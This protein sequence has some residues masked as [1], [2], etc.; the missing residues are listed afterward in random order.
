MDKSSSRSALPLCKRSNYT[1]GIF[2]GLGLV[3][4]TPDLQP[5]QLMEATLFR[6][7]DCG[8][9]QR[10]NPLIIPEIQSCFGH[11]HRTYA[12]HGD[13]GGPIVYK[14]PDKAS[15][16]M[17]ISS[18]IAPNCM[19]AHFPGIFTTAAEFRN[20]LWRTTRREKHNH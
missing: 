18:Y 3:S 5:N 20:W 7:Y 13:A 15:C 17:G 6:I 19:D 9:Y 14:P 8:F 11:P 12:C 4:Q 2:L 16:I 1:F 10:V